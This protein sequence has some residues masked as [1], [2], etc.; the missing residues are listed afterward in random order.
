M[1]KKAEAKD[2]KDRAP[3]KVRPSVFIVLSIP[4]ADAVINNGNESFLT[5]PGCEL[6]VACA[7][8]VLES[9]DEGCPDRRTTLSSSEE[10]ERWIEDHAEDGF[11]YGIA[12]VKVSK[13][14][15][16]GKFFVPCKVETKP[17]RSFGG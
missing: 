13:L 11:S 17:V 16:D 14:S 7:T 12:Q 2:N 15:T 5:K 3:R 6:T 1:A 8:K 10:C 4:T 9:P